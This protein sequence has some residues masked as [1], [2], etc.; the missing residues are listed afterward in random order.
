MGWDVYTTGFMMAT[1]LRDAVSCL[2][3]REEKGWFGRFDCLFGL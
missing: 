2:I 1:K 3:S